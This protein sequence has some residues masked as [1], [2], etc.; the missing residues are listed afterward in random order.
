MNSAILEAGT[1]YLAISKVSLLPVSFR[2]RVCDIF[3]L[4]I[5][6]RHFFCAS[7]TPDPELPVRATSLM[8]VLNRLTLSGSQTGDMTRE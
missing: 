2:V 7:K 3:R 8:T 4:M 5:P 6:S 1:K